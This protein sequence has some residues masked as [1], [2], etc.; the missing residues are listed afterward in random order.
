MVGSSVGRSCPM[1]IYV[2]HTPHCTSGPPYVIAD[3]VPYEHHAVPLPI[4]SPKELTSEMAPKP[5]IGKKRK[6]WGRLQGL[7]I[8]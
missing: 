1:P 4:G 7:S 2:T 8:K 5:S 3:Q 6:V